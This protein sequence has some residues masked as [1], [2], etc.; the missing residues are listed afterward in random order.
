MRRISMI[1]HSENH[2]YG[3]A[4]RRC[5][6]NRIVQ[7]Y[8]ERV[9]SQRG[10]SPEHAK[11]ET[12]MPWHPMVRL[13]KHI[14]KCEW[15]T[16]ESWAWDSAV[17]CCEWV[18]IEHLRFTRWSD[19]R[20]CKKSA[21]RI[22][23]LLRFKYMFV[24]CLISDDCRCRIVVAI[25]FALYSPSCSKAGVFPILAIHQGS[26]VNPSQICGIFSLHRRGKYLIC[27]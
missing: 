3:N 16:A 19:A 6:L 5:F 9:L 15:L 26:C 25:H 24:V 12:L 17:V 8:W 7:F 23:P 18:V 27:K 13:R 1:F 10:K 20:R 21:Q 2:R 14:W 4:V 11:L 22:S